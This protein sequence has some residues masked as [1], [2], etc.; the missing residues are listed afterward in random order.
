MYFGLLLYI[1]EINLNGTLM[2]TLVFLGTIGLTWPILDM[3][4]YRYCPDYT[5][6]VTQASQFYFGQTDYVYISAS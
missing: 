1:L 2:R 4:F 3:P 6:Y 5:A